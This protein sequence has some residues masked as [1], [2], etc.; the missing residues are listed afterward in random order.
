MKK[1]LSWFYRIVLALFEY[2][3]IQLA[4][5]FVLWTVFGIAWRALIDD[6]ALA[7]GLPFV[8]G[9]AVCAL[10]IWI[11][12]R[13]YCLTMSSRAQPPG[14]S[15]ICRWYVLLVLLTPWTTFLLA[16]D[17]WAIDAF[18]D[19]LSWKALLASLSATIVGATLEE[20]SYRLVLIGLMMRA[21]VPVV[22]VL[23]VQTTVFVL[24]HHPAPF[25]GPHAL[26]WY[27]T[28][29]ATLG[30][31]YLAGRSL[32]GTILLHVSINVLLAQVWPQHYWIAPRPVE[33]FH[34]DWTRTC[35]EVLAALGA[36][37]LL[38]LAWA[39]WRSS[40]HHPHSPWEHDRAADQGAT[41][42]QSTD[43]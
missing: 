13:R 29:S 37:L 36:G 30:A 6:S 28:V 22:L 20:M 27:T 9:L 17:R 21:D 15:V 41:L 34:M 42:L 25:L 10:P 19:L 3:C 1:T 16:A 23:A 31:V 11:L 7:F 5:L 4:F 32:T 39:H 26:F 24:G 43:G 14:R 2:G 12:R 35:A 8:V 40:R 38:T 33:S 18:I